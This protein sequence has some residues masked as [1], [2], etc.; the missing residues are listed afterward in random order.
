MWLE[1]NMHLMLYDMIS[2]MNMTKLCGINLTFVI[3]V[4]VVVMFIA[5]TMSQIDQNVV[6]QHVHVNRL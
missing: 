5:S 3:I 6:L 1:S 2:D 4:V